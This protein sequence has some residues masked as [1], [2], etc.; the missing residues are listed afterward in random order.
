MYADIS[1][2]QIILY[3]T[4]CKNEVSFKSNHF[5]SEYYLDDIYM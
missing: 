2:L 3:A 4:L 5:R 1:R